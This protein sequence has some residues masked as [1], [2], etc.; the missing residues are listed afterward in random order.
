MIKYNQ[1]L[2]LFN[3]KI[4]ELNIYNRANIKHKIDFANLP[5]ISKNC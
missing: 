1:A 2:I 5:K 4:R 3:L